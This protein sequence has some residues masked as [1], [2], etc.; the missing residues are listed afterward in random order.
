MQAL[1]F[2]SVL[3]QRI[4]YVVVR[5]SISNVAVHS[6]ARQ[7]VQVV[8]RLQHS[9][10]FDVKNSLHVGI[11]KS[12]AKMPHP[13]SNFLRGI[14]RLLISAVCVHILMSCQDFVDRVK[15][16]LDRI[17]FPEPVEK[18]VWKSAE[19]SIP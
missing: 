14:Q 19:V 18:L 12:L 15:L 9:A 1:K 8:E 11:G 7:R 3:G 4:E 13:I 2:V 17:A 5:E 6:F 16:G 10:M